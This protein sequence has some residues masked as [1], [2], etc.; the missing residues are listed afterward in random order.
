LRLA[1]PQIDIELVASDR[2]ENLLQREADI[3]V[4][5][6]RPTQVDVVTRKLGDL[7]LGM[8]AAQSYLD[9]RGEPGSLDELKQHEVIG[10][11]KN[12]QMIRGFKEAGYEVT[13]G[14]FSFRC[15]NQVVCWQMV[16]AGYGIGINQ[17]YIGQAEPGLKQIMAHADLPALPIWLTAHAELKS[18]RRVRRVYDFLAE[19]L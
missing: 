18:S 1:E 2:T 12:D 16:L 13:S 5:M 4:R 3:A 8:F 17:I 7:Q 19:H 15:D 11:D 9:R 6:Y 10:Y 14:F